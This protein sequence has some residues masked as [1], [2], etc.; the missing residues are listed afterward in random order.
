MNTFR[1]VRIVQQGNETMC[2]IVRYH[3]KNKNKTDI[4]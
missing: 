2:R 3:E 4:Y 1:N